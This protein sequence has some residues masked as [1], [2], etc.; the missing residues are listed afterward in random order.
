MKRLDSKSLKILGELKDEVLRG[1]YSR[2]H[3]FPS[4]IALSRRFDVSRSLI[5]GVVRE[6]ERMGLVTR[7]QGRGTFVTRQA[8]QRKVGL[9]IPD[10]SQ[11]E[12]FMRIVRSLMRVAELEDYTLLFKEVNGAD[13]KSRA[14]SA[15]KL[16]SEL[17]EQNVS[18]VLFQPI[19][20]CAGGEAVNRRMLAQ[21]DAAS[22]P[23]VICDNDVASCDGRHDVVGVNNIR[24]GMAMYRHLMSVGAKK[25]CFFMRPNAPQSHEDRLLGM[26][27]E[28]FSNRAEI[29]M[30][31]IRL[32]LE[33]DDVP[34]IR[35]RIRSGHVNAFMCGDDETAA[36][37]IRTLNK[38]G[39]SV[40]Q[41]IMVSGF[42][43]LHLASHL[44]PSLT[45][46]RIPCEQ[47]AEVA[48]RR[49]IA[50]IA[51][52]LLPPTE[53]FLPVEL[54]ERESCRRNV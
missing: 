29:A 14:R 24:A 32:V 16:V 33:P 23:V 37:L 34:A 26:V 22:I 5:T 36:V 49:L 13:A 53:Q 3:S 40:P 30:R 54:I 45:T 25:V 17:I 2:E 38:L 9:V 44:S 1:K 12:Y 20:Y 39:R 41:E 48:F 35:R 43:D 19:E 18:G 21:L 28:M 42:N 4:E 15:E 10:S 7:Y 51:N 47:I 31:D 46:M 11:T 27:A 50:R 6:L 52:P 8:S